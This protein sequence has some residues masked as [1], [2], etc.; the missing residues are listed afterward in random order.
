MNKE[1][2][3]VALTKEVCQEE[4]TNGRSNEKHQFLKIETVSNGCAS[5]IVIETERWAI[6]DREDWIALW[7]KHIEP[8]SKEVNK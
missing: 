7:D 6:D 2:E 4:D 3:V 1:K 5:Y 8:M